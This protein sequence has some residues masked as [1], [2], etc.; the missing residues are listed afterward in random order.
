MNSNGETLADELFVSPNGH[1]QDIGRIYN[2]GRW[3]NEERY[4][5]T[6][7]LRHMLLDLKVHAFGRM[8]HKNVTCFRIQPS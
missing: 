2:K 8:L 3:T 1:R 7:T 4:R 6:N 5:T